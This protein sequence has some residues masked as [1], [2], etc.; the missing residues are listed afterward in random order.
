MDSFW[1]HSICVGVTAKSLADHKRIPAVI[2]EEYFIS[3]L[4]HDLGKIP[5]SDCFS[6]EYEK[7]LYLANQQNADLL[8]AESSIFGFNHCDTGR[9]IAEK[10]KLSDSILNTLAYHHNPDQVDEEIRNM[11]TLVAVGNLYSNYFKIGS[12]G[13]RE[14]Q[15]SDFAHILELSGLNWEEVKALDEKVRNEIE[16]AQIFLKVG[17][18]I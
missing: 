1:S 5:L 8:L 13:E 10:W 2:Q 17:K 16:K 7:V 4:L 6:E 15:P 11:V 3:G 9:M 12:A 18:E 14:Q